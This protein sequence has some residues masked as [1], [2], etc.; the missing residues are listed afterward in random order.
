MKQVKRCLAML[1]AV[2]MAVTLM[3]QAAYWGQAA[4]DVESQALVDNAGSTSQEEM[5]P[6]DELEV[7]SDGVK[8]AAREVVEEYTFFTEGQTLHHT[9]SDSQYYVF[10]PETSGWYYIQAESQNKEDFRIDWDY[11]IYYTEN[12]DGSQTEHQNWLYED[13]GYSNENN[14]LNRLMWL[15]AGNKYFY[16]CNVTSYNDRDNIDI[17]LTL[18]QAEVK[19]IE[20]VTH[21]TAVTDI[22]LG[23]IDYTGLQ[24]KINYTD[25]NSVISEVSSDGYV[26]VLEWADR[27][28]NSTSYYNEYIRNYIY[29]NKIDNNVEYEFENLAD[30]EHTVEVGIE[31][32]KYDEQGYYVDATDFLFDITF[33]AEKK[34]IKSID[35]IGLDTT[36]TYGMGENLTYDY[37]EIRYENK[38]VETINYG[39]GYDYVK[40]R[41]VH[42]NGSYTPYQNIDSFIDVGGTLGTNTVYVTY[43]D[44]TIEREIQ[45]ADNPYERVELHLLQDGF[46]ANC[47]FEF[48]DYYYTENNGEYIDYYDFSVTLYRKDG[49]VENYDSIYAAPGENY[50]L[51]GIKYT[52]Q[53][54]DYDGNI[55]EDYNY[56]RHIDDFLEAGGV[57]GEN[58]VE[59][60]ICALEVEATIEIFANPYDHIKIAKLP[61]K[62]SYVH[63]KYAYLSNQGMEIHAY[64]DEVETEDN[65]DVYTYTEDS[66]SGGPVTN[67][68]KYLYT[69]LG[70]H[71]NIQY[72]ELGT[73]PVHVF[74]M[75]H[76]ASFEIEVVEQLA[77]SVEVLQTP[78]D[79]AYYVGE[80]NEHR[81]GINL[82]GLVISITDMNDNVRNYRYGQYYVSE[83]YGD[84]DDISSDFS[85]DTSAV[86]WNTPGSYE[87]E[88]SYL[89]AVDTFEV[90]L[91]ANPI[92]S[93]EIT[94]MP[95]KTSYFQYQETSVD[96]TGMSYR[97]TFTDDT[98]YERTLTPNEDNWYESISIRY[99]GEYY[100]AEPEWDKYNSEGNPTIGNNALVFNFFGVEA[101]TDIIEVLENP[102][103]SLELVKNPDKTFYLGGNTTVDIY[104]AEILITYSDGT[105]K[106]VVVEEHTNRVAVDDDY[107]D[108][109][110][111]YI[112]TNWSQ[113]DG[114][115]QSALFINYMNI[116]KWS[117]FTTDLK[118]FES[119]ELELERQN[120]LNIN[121]EQEYKIYTYT[122]ET[123][124]TYYLHNLCSEYLQVRMYGYDTF[125]YSGESGS[126]YSVSLIEGETYYFVVYGSLNSDETEI[127][128][129][130]ALSTNVTSLSTL[131]VSD[132]E[133]T[134][135]PKDTWYDFESS[136]IWA[137]EIEL[138]G[139]EI[140][141]TY[142]N[143]WK[144]NKALT[145]YSD[146]MNLYGKTLSIAWKYVEDVDGDPYVSIRE[147]NALV[148][149]Y[150]DK[151]VELPVH[152]NVE[153]P[154]AAITITNNPLSAKGLYQYQLD[155][156]EYSLEGLTATVTYKDGRESAILTW[157]EDEDGDVSNPALNGYYGQ[158][159][160]NEIW[161]S[162]GEDEEVTYQLVVKYM[163]CEESITLDVKENPISDIEILE[164]PEKM[165]ICPY[166]SFTRD[167]YGLKVKLIFDDGTSQI[168]EVTEHCKTYAVDNGYS[169]KLESYTNYYYDEEDLEYRRLYIRYMGLSR[170][171][172]VYEN[173]PMSECPSE[174]IRLNEVKS[175]KFDAV[176][177][178]Y[179]Y[180]FTPVESGVYRFASFNNR[181]ETNTD[182]WNS[183]TYGMIYSAEGSRL[184]YNDDNEN[185]N[186]GMTY[187]M[188]AGKTYYLVVRMYDE[189]DIGQCDCSIT[190]E[191]D[192]DVDLVTLN[193]LNINISDP[194][195][196]RGLTDV[197]DIDLSNCGVVS[198]KW[199]GADEDEFASYGTAH[200]LKLVIEPND[201]YEF[202][203][204]TTVY[205]NGNKVKTKSVGNNGN[206]TL[207]HT[208]P[209]TDCKVTVP[210]VTGFDLC[211]DTNENIG[212]VPY[213][214]SYTFQYVP[215]EGYEDVRLIVK[216]GDKVLKA[217]D[218]VYTLNNV[219]S[220]TTIVVKTET[221]DV[222]TE[223]T[224]KITL[225]NLTEE[226]YDILTGV[227]GSTIAKNEEGETSLP[228]L[229]SYVDGSDLFFYGWYMDKDADGVGKGTR[230]TSLTSLTA[231]EYE[232]YAK[233]ASGI[234]TYIMNNK[235]VHYKI[236]SI[237]E[238][239]KTKVQVG[240]GRSTLSPVAFMARNRSTGE[241]TILEIPKNLDV[242]KIDLEALG[243]NLD[244]CEVVAIAPNAFAGEEDIVGITLPDTIESIG[245]NAF[246]G[247][248]S[249]KELAIPEAVTEI[250]ASAFNGCA[251][252]ENVTIP[253]SVTTIE[254]GTF[255]GCSNL[256]SVVLAD[257]VRAIEAN[258]FE[259]CNNLATIVL[260]DTI[261]TINTDAFANTQPSDLTIVCS[262]AV[263]NSNAVQSVQEA[264]NATVKVID[265]AFD[266]KYDEKVFT[267]GEEAWTLTASVTEDGNPVDGVVEWN[268][269]ST[270]AFNF[271]KNGNAISVTPLRALE[272]GETVQLSAKYAD[273][274]KH[275]TLRV[276]PID[277]EKVDA[278]RDAVY[279]VVVE[280]V[281]YTGSAIV[282]NVIVREKYGEKAVIDA[283]DYEVICS[284]N[285]SV[286]DAAKVTVRGKGNCVGTLSATFKIVAATIKDADVTLS[287]T[288]YI[289]SG[290]ECIPNI[291]VKMGNKEL[292][293]DE[294]YTIAYKN[295]K[296]V[297]TAVVT[298][299]GIGNYTGSTT[300][301]FTI[302]AAQETV[303]DAQV[304][305]NGADITL[306]QTTYTYNGM[307]HKPT[308]T[309]K[310]G[311]TLLMQNTDYVVSYKNNKN[312]GTA[313]VTI[314]GIGK[315]KD[316]TT[317]NFTIT[318]APVVKQSITEKD[319]TLSATKYTCNEKEKKPS[320]IVKVGGKTLVQG[321]DY[322]LTY[323]NNK[324]IGTATV[325]VVGSGN[326]TGVVNKKFTITLA[327]GKTFSKGGYK[328]KVTGA[329]TVTFVGV[330]SAKTTSV[331]IADTVKYGGKTFKITVVADK[332][333]YKKNKVK[334][335]TIGKNVTTIGKSAFEGCTKLTNVSIG[336]KVT[337]IGD[338]AFKKCTALTKIT[339]PAKVKTIGKEA[340]YGSKKLKTIT[341]KSTNLTSV[342]KNAFKGIHAKAT[343]KVPKSKLK[344][345][346][347]VMKSK[348]QGKKVKIKK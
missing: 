341:V 148:Y 83:E 232:L 92:A 8:M 26:D 141:I 298:I 166:E 318:A 267:Y 36:Y 254:E 69:Q 35:I 263:A 261:E 90:I 299:T 70:G 142:G 324:N 337:K 71:E 125:S 237:D 151:V 121:T 86:D 179:V 175:I 98:V 328:Y 207:Y 12:E 250:G 139:T 147:D 135:V 339:I 243:V 269:T 117:Y 146:S 274:T 165:I 327:K 173:V 29:I 3:P 340:F 252:L 104:G 214:G 306:S 242:N 24:V 126:S 31:Y 38:E 25:E 47:G 50:A 154:V 17:A 34:V 343:I 122:P 227:I 178:Y 272:E 171:V 238:N 196:G 225:H 334:N 132:L 153:T 271:V 303:K 137:G 226:I 248:T 75:G 310:V 170:Q 52:Y 287:Q 9:S 217:E 66:F 15:N 58:I 105:K 209:Y 93:F 49:G 81:Y 57:I 205:V 342:G 212:T 91:E 101:K 159:N 28:S 260:P 309:V 201:G 244:E 18:H 158:A 278:D 115:V 245:A 172:G 279:E 223:T 30:G 72:L 330:T 255:S 313:T 240:D 197:Y 160:I 224:A 258:A 297:G 336:S 189:G 136:Y 304:S 143:G 155:N 163:G 249:L 198:Y 216:A 218:G 43:K 113:D 54:E 80:M 61:D 78:D 4:N 41:Y 222:E 345:Y 264:T 14:Q 144:M 48:E 221:V 164:Q 323:K 33:Q 284:N 138:R 89:G 190:K 247:C 131:E 129:S 184:A 204:T 307:E 157:T 187:T 185:L 60:E 338:K 111:A 32:Y 273:K 210:N 321:I 156:E 281:V 265:I 251:S 22:E 68:D 302:K 124:G 87:V 167:L 112:Y 288:E 191:Q 199:T 206:L 118:E 326:Y 145:S 186:F 106:T 123:S 99:N 301:N 193:E 6:S 259:G 183:D 73:H 195:A 84:W 51:Y 102:I 53:Y 348:G 270:N 294:D 322:T 152:L 64:K 42:D 19:S 174:E 220:N 77:K 315:Y 23:R 55:C 13:S 96:L 319:V 114:V 67:A 268:W 94:H 291:T 128:L 37:I 82:S 241:G 20:T 169:T 202:V 130:F 108:E 46:Y 257:G 228:T 293:K 300:R 289:Y 140:A 11:Y 16:Q 305:I 347:K 2:I 262:S 110:Y 149:T 211:Q 59:A 7:K 333:L 253:S 331:K 235:E 180:A 231:P 317:R 127:E 276:E 229:E 335:V 332:A 79:I 285:T 85:Y 208:F 74:F 200:V 213:A 182:S 150:G 76:Y 56:Y 63:N 314:T 27:S 296:N 320:V 194:V 239:N 177:Q 236:L 5:T 103:Q 134:K 65:Y 290:K 277:L 116:N 10:A 192:V 107:S 162:T 311:N 62:T 275:I 88:V 168:V 286:T 21:P 95:D 181:V 329:S 266:C 325:T 203:S 283:S 219:T 161:V 119:E 44:V 230:F 133:I 40:L 316:S 256:T 233:W 45:I 346:Q 120:T 246:E 344:A 39:Y 295:N 97:V 1:L 109:L 292:Q 215:Q 308:V 282:P 176:N 312:V 100:S 234:F 280:D 188:T